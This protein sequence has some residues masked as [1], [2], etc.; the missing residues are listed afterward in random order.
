MFEYK[1]GQLVRVYLA[2]Y[3]GANVLGKVIDDMAFPTMIEGKLDF[4]YEILIITSGIPERK[5]GSTFKTS[6]FYMES[7]SDIEIQCLLEYPDT[8]RFIEI[9][10]EEEGVNEPE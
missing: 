7:L 1:L 9:L 5:P 2:G 4:G 8:R 10:P 3:K 6:G